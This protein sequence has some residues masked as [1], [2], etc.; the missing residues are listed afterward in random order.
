[1]ILK[2]KAIGRQHCMYY[3]EYIANVYLWLVRSQTC[4]LPAACFVKPQN[5]LEVAIILKAVISRRNLPLE[6]VDIMLMLDSAA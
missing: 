5:A 6:A 1:M 4:W 3:E 2:R